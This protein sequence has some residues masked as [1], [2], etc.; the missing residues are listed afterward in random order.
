MYHR[1]YLQA[2]VYTVLAAFLRLV[3]RFFFRTIEVVGRDRVP[4]EGAVIFV[5][6]HPNSL[7]DPVLIT[8]TCGRQVRF[9]ARDGLFSTPVRPILWALGSVPIRRKEDQHA[10]PEAAH[11][12][13]H[14]ATPRATQKA[15]QHNVVTFRLMRRWSKTM[16]GR[17]KW[18]SMSNAM[19]TLYNWLSERAR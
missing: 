7:V 16:K 19:T 15:T 4:R 2:I 14:E 9:A 12:A 13:A 6:N 5:G 10:A 3:T 8:T 18:P 11:E 17:K 1:G